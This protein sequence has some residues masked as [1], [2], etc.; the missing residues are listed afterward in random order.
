MGNED[1]LQ[2]SQ[3]EASM[4]NEDQVKNLPADAG[5]ELGS[6][7]GRV[8][9]QWKG[10]NAEEFGV[11]SRKKEADIAALIRKSKTAL[12]PGTRVLEIGFGNG[13]F[14]AYGK[15]RHWEMHGTEVNAGLLGR[16]RQEGF[17]VVH[18]DNLEPFPDNHF[19]LV[20]AFD[21]LEHLPQDKL[22]GFLREIQRVL[23]DGG[24]FIARFPNGDSPFGG[25]LQHGDPT[26]I[27]TIGSLMARYFANKTGMEIAYLGGE[28]QPLWAGLPQFAY[29]AFAIPI[30]HMMN[31]FINL[32]FSP[33]I[34]IAFC[35]P[36]LVMVFRAVKPASPAR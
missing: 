21:V 4:S 31:L 35:S 14:L 3:T 2:A 27:T 29:R 25:F 26:H 12:P 13:S 17:R 36:N 23:G 5:N 30:R 20:A 7:Y 18:S 15:K 22:E 1:W 9:L 6:G 24:I 33:R 34:R 16:A 10:W 11:L 28:P 8:Y 19:G 32:I